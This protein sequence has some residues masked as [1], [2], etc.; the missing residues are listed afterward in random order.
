MYLLA[1][2]LMKCK[3]MPKLHK[4]IMYIMK[5][6]HYYYLIMESLSFYLY[7]SFVPESVVRRLSIVFYTTMFNPI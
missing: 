3:I 1:P 5:N 2:Q 7:P 6:V 4:T